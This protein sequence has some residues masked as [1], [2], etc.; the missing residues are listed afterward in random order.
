VLNL[1]ADSLNLLNGEIA[2]AKQEYDSALDVF[3]KVISLTSDDYMRYRAYH[4]SD[5]IFKLLGEP[6]RSVELLESALNRIPLNRVPEM[7]ERLADAYVKNGDYDNAIQL[8][9]QLAENGAPQFHIMQDLAILL[10]NI[11]DFDRAAIVLG[12]MTDLFPNDYRVPMRQAYLEADRQSKIINE[13]REYALTKQ[14]Y[15]RAAQLYA[16]NIR[17]G[18]SDP[19]MQ[20]LDYLIAQLQTNKWID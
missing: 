19:E 20:Q 3:G 4:T 9:E 11:A 1:D 6:V 2:F 13:S 18:E 15:D 17:P 8:F 16:D 14:Y 5:E 7:T 12:D 10:Q